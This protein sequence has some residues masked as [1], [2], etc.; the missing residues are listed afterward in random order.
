M[1]TPLPSAPLTMVSF[2]FFC[3]LIPNVP[4]AEVL[5]SQQVLPA[6]CGWHGFVFAPFNDG[7]AAWRWRPGLGFGERESFVWKGLGLVGRDSSC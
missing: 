5:G 3:C 1:I 4:D 2:V 6:G 7:G